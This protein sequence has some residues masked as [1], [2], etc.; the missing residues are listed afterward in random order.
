MNL[1]IKDFM[2]IV[3]YDGLFEWVDLPSY[4]AAQCIIDDPEHKE[5]FCEPVSALTVRCYYPIESWIKELKRRKD[6]ETTLTES[7]KHRHVR[8]NEFLS[9][10]EL[11]KLIIT[12]TIMGNFS[13]VTRLGELLNKIK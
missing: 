8:P 7:L 3:T 4:I 11:Q 13:E 5:V 9:K 10:S 12:A 6:I 1:K 2:D